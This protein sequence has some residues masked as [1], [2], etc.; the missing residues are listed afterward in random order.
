MAAAFKSSRRAIQ[1]G[2]GAECRAADR[3]PPP[4][5]RAD[6]EVAPCNSPYYCAAV[7]GKELSKGREAAF[8]LAQ[9]DSA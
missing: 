9:G 8:C 1:D 3:P 5:G 4:R 7:T 6:S 2:G